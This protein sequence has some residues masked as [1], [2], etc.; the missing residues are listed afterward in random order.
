M[1]PGETLHADGPKKAQ[2]EPCRPPYRDRG[3]AWK[4]FP[5]HISTFVTNNPPS[6]GSFE[7][8]YSPQTG[9]VGLFNRVDS[10]CAWR[11]P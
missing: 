10:M 3:P 6:P 9:L 8:G 2:P 5:C 4:K 7:M 11:G 1:S